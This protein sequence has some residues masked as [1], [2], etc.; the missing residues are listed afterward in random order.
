[1]TKRH[2]ATV[3]V[4][5]F[6]TFTLYAYYWL[7]RTTKEL[8]EETEREDLNPGMDVILTLV[9]MGLWGIWAGYRNAKITHEELE[10]RGEKHTDRSI[11][12]AAFGCLTFMSG[13]AWLVSLALLQDDFNRLADAEFDFFED[14][15]P[16]R[17]P[18]HEPARR[19]V[20]ARVEVEPMES[21]LGQSAWSDAPSAPVFEST[22]PA[23][24]V[25]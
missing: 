4:L 12:V 3:V 5:T 10:A 8:R 20:R 21:P 24:V 19:P 1:M 18:A 22:A 16:A 14:A 6:L 11:A 9:T 17:E 2:P 25:F 23:P 7:Y 13:W 15:A